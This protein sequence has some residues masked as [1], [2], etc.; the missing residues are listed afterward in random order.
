MAFHFVAFLHT[1]FALFRKQVE[2]N[3]SNTSTLHVTR[4]GETNSADWL[5][6]IVSESHL[7]CPRLGWLGDGWPRG[8]GIA[9]GGFGEWSRGNRGGVSIERRHRTVC[10]PRRCGIRATRFYMRHGERL[11]LDD[12]NLSVYTIIK[13]IKSNNSIFFIKTFV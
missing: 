11:A 5:V 8:A 10:R 6:N 13:R 3:N 12:R 9:D 7:K 4:L 2:Q 1:P